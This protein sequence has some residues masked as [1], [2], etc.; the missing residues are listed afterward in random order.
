M[1]EWLAVWGVGHFIFSPVLEDL[2]EDVREDVADSYGNLEK[3]CVAGI[4]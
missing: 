1:I 2:A 4:A 3:R